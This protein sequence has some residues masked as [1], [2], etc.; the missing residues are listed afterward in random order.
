MHHLS[1]AYSGKGSKAYPPAM[2]I[3]LLFYGYATGVFSSRK[4]EKATY[5]S[6]AFRYICANTNADH[7]IDEGC[8]FLGFNFRK[9]HGELLIKL[10]KDSIAAVKGKI[11][12]G[13]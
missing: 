11:R 9:Y 8:D 3:A 5:D 7:D 4:L 13:L 2:L 6:V 12:A 1:T 10:A